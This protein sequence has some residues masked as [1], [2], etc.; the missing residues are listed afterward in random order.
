MH[1]LTQVVP[2]KAH[3]EDLFHC[4]DPHAVLFALFSLQCVKALYPITILSRVIV[5]DDF[6][7]RIDPTRLLRHMWNNKRLLS[8]Q[9][10]LKRVYDLHAATQGIA[11]SGGTLTLLRLA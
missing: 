11:C 1:R 2:Q 4:E 8:T 9:M 5:S 10:A 6:L 3:R 7:I